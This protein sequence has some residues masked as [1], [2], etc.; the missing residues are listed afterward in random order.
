MLSSRAIVLSGH[1]LARIIRQRIRSEVAILNSKF[2]LYPKLT[3]IEVGHLNESALYIEHKRK[4][5]LQCGIEL[6]H[7][8]LPSHCTKASLLEVVHRSNE[9]PTV[10]GIMLQVRCISTAGTFTHSVDLFNCKP[11]CISYLFVC[12]HIRPTKP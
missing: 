10:H 8:K 6:A 2:N 4:F 5:A 3:V 7:V 12:C 9:D 1:G 11:D